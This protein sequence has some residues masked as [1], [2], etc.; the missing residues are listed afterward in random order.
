MSFSTRKIL[1]KNK[2]VPI[3]V[4]DTAGQER[5]RS[6]TSAYFRGSHGVFLCFAINDRHTFQNLESWNAEVNNFCPADVVRM[7]VATKSDL[8]EEHR[9]VTEEEAQSYAASISA[10]YVE[11]SAKLNHN[12]EFALGERLCNY[13]FTFFIDATHTE[14]M[15]IQMQ[16]SLALAPALAPATESP[17]DLPP[18][19]SAGVSASGCC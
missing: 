19:Y 9:Q 2:L 17:F 13:D 14:N 12:V 5:Y 3:A 8:A 11:T 4:W 7:V 18:D 6:L 10:S 1:V 15:C 16:T